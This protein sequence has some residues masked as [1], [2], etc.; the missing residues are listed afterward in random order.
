[1]R[2]DLGTLDVVNMN[3]L[4][5]TPGPWRYTPWHIEEGNPTVRAPEGWLICETSSDA[6]ARLIAAAPDLL[7]ALKR[8][9]ARVDPDYTEV[10]T[11]EAKAAID[12]ALGR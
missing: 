6:N 2:S 5:H 11:L 3:E 12:K 9:V 1:M 8:L 4:K 10:E 7:Q